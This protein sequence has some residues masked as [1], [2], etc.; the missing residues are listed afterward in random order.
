MNIQSISVCVP[1]K[2]CINDCKFCCSKMHAADYEDRFTKLN[3]YDDYIKDMRKRL[4]YARQNG[5]NTCMLTGNNE[6]QQNKEFLRIFAEINRSLSAPFLNIEMQ[7]SGAYIDDGMLNFLKNTVGVTTIAI[8]VACISNP[9]KNIELIQTP[10][11]NLNISKLAE[12]IKAKNMNLRICLN[13]NDHMLDG[14][15]SMEDPEEAVKDIISRCKYLNADQI[16]CRA[17]WTSE[18]GTSQAEWINQN[19]TSLTHDVIKEFKKQ[20]KEDGKYLDT[21]EY[22]ADRY[23]FKGF[24]TVIDEDSMAQSQEKKDSVKYLILRP[25]GKLYSKWD[26]KASLIF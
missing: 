25:N 3:T 7:T 26:S 4:E 9:E 17:L 6:P 21:L 20:A 12:S 5:C 19:V 2:R 11:K 16:T 15:N 22:G 24:S 14:C 10:D 18:D 23:D 8:S 13:M 1:A